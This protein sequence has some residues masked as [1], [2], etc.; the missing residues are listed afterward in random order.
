MGWIA[1]SLPESFISDMNHFALRGRQIP[2]QLTWYDRMM[3]IIA[4]MKNKDPEA[5]KQEF[6]GFD[7]MDKSSIEPILELAGHFQLS[8]V[9]S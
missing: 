5:S 9:F 8:E 6:E 3:L 7:F 4:A 2:K 1:D